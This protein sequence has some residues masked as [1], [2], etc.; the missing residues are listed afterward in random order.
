MIPINTEFIRNLPLETKGDINHYLKSLL[1]YDSE[2]KKSP[3]LNFT[4][5]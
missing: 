5:I 1:A 3:N 4:T 2:L